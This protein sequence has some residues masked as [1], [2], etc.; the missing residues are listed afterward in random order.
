LEQHL[1]S[2]IRELLVGLD[3]FLLREVAPRAEALK[4]LLD[5]PHRLHGPDGR[6]HLDVMATRRDIRM[7]ASR[8][9]YYQMFVPT[10]LGG[11]GHDMLTMYAVWHRL[12]RQQGMRDWLA[13]DAVAHWATGPSHLMSLY[14]PQALDAYREPLMSGDLSMCFAISEA[15]AG[16]DLWRM[17]TTAER[18]DGGWR[19]NGEKQWQTNGPY[20]DLVTVFAVTDREAARARKGGIS[21]FVLPMDTPG[22]GVASVIR[23]YGRSGSNEAT[24]GFR[25]VIVPDWSL[26]GA[27]GDGMRIGLSGTGLGRVYNSAR[28][29]ALGAWAIDRATEYALLRQTFG[30]RL[31]DH[32]A[33]GFSLA[34]AATEIMAAKLLGL[35]TVRLMDEGRPALAEAAMMKSFS[36]E[37]AVRAIDRAAQALGGMGLTNEMYLQDAW[38]EMRAVCISDGSAQMMRRLICK[39]LADGRIDL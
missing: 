22:A 28:A 38:Q 33:I 17:T 19:I 4:D 7:A 13:F 1:P 32:Q 5:D 23:L 14:T 6:L 21:A 35:H 29:V 34:E 24:V 37:A 36:T 15:A 12:Y 3:G 27:E 31:I 39:E 8:A 10:E 30:K 26:V 11:G 25:D 18:I 2:E 16:S 20:A 9:G